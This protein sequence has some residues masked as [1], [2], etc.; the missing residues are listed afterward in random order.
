ML[1]TIYKS[2]YLSLNK[3]LIS[4]M[5][6]ETL[7]ID[8]KQVAVAISLAYFYSESKLFLIDYDLIERDLNKACK[9][10]WEEFFN[11]IINN[12]EYFNNIFVHNLGSFD[13]YFIY[14]EM[15]N[16]FK[17]DEVSTII[18]DKNKFIQIVLKKANFEI[19][20]KDSY[21]I[22]PLSLDNLCKNFMVKGKISKYDIRFNNLDLFKDSNLLNEFKNYSLQDSICLL[23]A[24]NMAQNIYKIDY[25][26]DITSILSTSTLSLKIFRK[27]FLKINIPIIRGW[28]DNFIRKAYLGGS[29]DYYKAYGE[30]LKYYDINS[31]YPMAMKKPMPFEIIKNHSDLSNVKLEDFFGFC[32]AEIECPKDIKIP[33]LPHKFEGKT[34]FPTG[35]WTSVYFSE[36]LKA[37]KPHGYKINLIKGYEFSKTN[38][39]NEYVD[40]FYEKKKCA[41]N[42]SDRFIAKMHLNQLYGIFG[43]KQELIE[44]INVY[45]KDLIKYVGHR[46]IK[47]IIEI[48]SEISTLLLITNINPEIT[49]ELNTSLNIK[50]NSKNY[51]IVKSNVAI[52]AAVTSYARIHM[53]QFKL[54]DNIYYTDTDSIF[55]SEELSHDLVGRDLGLMKDELSGSI[56]KEAYF[57]GIKQYGYYYHDKENKKITKSVFAGVSRDSLTFNEIEDIYSNKTIEKKIQNRF[58]K[59]LNN[60]NITIK[61]TKISIKKNI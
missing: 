43:R 57:L 13:G 41:T 34:I 6:I 39:F 49:S 21:R 18:D 11:F 50:L 61:S 22:F 7:D 27:M 48:N 25:N 16:I 29:T 53:I 4:A 44:T 17:P 14:K 20:W 45:N 40:H 46:L 8:G 30:N 26:T 47:S 28:I 2:Y 52:A 9:L 35:Q 55:T 54:N 33:L 59:S 23:E 56:I 37:V 58:Y 31:L 3:A 60:L 5:D 32:L 12:N 19:I 51:N 38:L 36:E 15:S 10:L 1:F 42:P 24:L